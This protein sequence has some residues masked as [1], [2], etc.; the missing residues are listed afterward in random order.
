MHRNGCR[1]C[2]ASTCT[3]STNRDIQHWVYTTDVQTFR[4][5]FLSF[6]LLLYLA[7]QLSSHC[8]QHQNIYCL[9]LLSRSLPVR[10]FGL[11]GMLY[12]QS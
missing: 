3:V 12:C 4:Q 8:H 2:C 1:S 9:S 7:Y 5:L 10:R 6:N 11:S